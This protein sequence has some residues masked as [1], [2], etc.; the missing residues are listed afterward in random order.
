[1]VLDRMIRWISLI[2]FLLLSVAV[3]PGV[4]S[5][6]AIIV[7]MIAIYSRLN[8]PY[9]PLAA[10]PVAYCFISITPAIEYLLLVMNLRRSERIRSFLK[11]ADNLGMRKQRVDGFLPLRPGG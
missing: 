3:F 2:V 1:M 11:L 9:M 6:F 7:S 4:I 10:V 5:F 8:R